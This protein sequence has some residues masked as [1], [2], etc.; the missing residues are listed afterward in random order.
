MLEHHRKQIVDVQG[1]NSAVL[2][3]DTVW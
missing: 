2:G 1:W 3:L